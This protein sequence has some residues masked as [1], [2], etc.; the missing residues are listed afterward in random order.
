MKLIGL[1]TVSILQAMI[2]M[3]IVHAQDEQPSWYIGPYGAIMQS[4]HTTG[5]KDIPGY[6]TC[7]FSERSGTGI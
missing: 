1:F 4:I 2:G 7:C 3:T 5:F 6:P